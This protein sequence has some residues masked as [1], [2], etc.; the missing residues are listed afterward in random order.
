MVGSAIVLLLAGG[1]KASQRE[2]VRAAQRRWKDYLEVSNHGQ[3]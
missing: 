3:A 1:D 2:D